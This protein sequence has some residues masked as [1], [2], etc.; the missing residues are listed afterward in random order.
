MP[1][2]VLFGL[3]WSARPRSAREFEKRN[4]P[5]LIAPTPDDAAPVILRHTALDRVPDGAG[6]PHDRAPRRDSECRT[7]PHGSEVEL[8]PS[9]VAVERDR[10]ERAAVS[11]P[12]A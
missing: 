8:P 3:R 12:V 11:T 6:A 1:E 9:D 5:A 7:S 10:Q 2:L 4:S